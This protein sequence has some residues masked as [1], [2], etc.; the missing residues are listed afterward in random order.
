MRRILPYIIGLTTALWLGGLVTLF[1]ALISI[2]R[3]NR[4][5]GAQVGP[6]LFSKFEPYQIGLGLIAIVCTV[7][8][9]MY[10]CSRAKKLL[11][12]CLIAA[13]SIAVIS[14]AY[15]TPQITQMASDE[16]ANA[17]EKFAKLHKTSEMMYRA[18]A[19]LVL[20]AFGAFIAAM[21]S[22]AEIVPK[23]ARPASES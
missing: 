7:V 12:A 10:A 4:G 18:L 20:I 16:V 11:L 15:L 3:Y 14:F 5:I 9:R 19:V 23:H 21:K 2:F 1:I 17:S 13:V 8:W 22:E 6:V